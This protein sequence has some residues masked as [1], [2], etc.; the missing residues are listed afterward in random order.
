MLRLQWCLSNFGVGRLLKTRSR[1]SSSSASM[2]LSRILF[3]SR[4]RLTFL[5]IRLPQQPP[6]NRVPRYNIDL[7]LHGQ[8]QTIRPLVPQPEEPRLALRNDILLLLDGNVLRLAPSIL[9]A[10]EQLAHQVVSV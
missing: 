8:N 4:E 7:L 9:L 3:P 6:V 5:V 1:P 10:F 2:L